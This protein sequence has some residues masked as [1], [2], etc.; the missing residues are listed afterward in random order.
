MIGKQYTLLMLV[1]IATGALAIGCAVSSNSITPAWVYKGS[2]AV[3]AF[4]DKAFHGV[5]RASGIKNQSLLRTTADNRARAEVAEILETYV[6]TL[7]RG[8][9]AAGGEERQRIGQALLSHSKNTLRSAVII[10]HWA[11]INTGTLYS[12]CKMDLASVRN[13]L[14]DT[15]GLDSEVRDYIRKNAGRVHEALEGTKSR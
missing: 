10:E 7:S 8:Y 6:L 9:T 15:E 3:A 12:L 4:G 14:A 2:G 13:I 5:G 1:V 11:D